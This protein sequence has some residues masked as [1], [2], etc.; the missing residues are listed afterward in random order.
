MIDV[1]K[2]IEEIY[3]PLPKTDVEYTEGVFPSIDIITNGIVEC[4]DPCACYT[5]YIPEGTKVQR[6][7][8]IRYGSCGLIED[9]TIFLIGEKYIIFNYFFQEPSPPSGYFH[10][11]E[12][13]TDLIILPDKT[14]LT[15]YREYEHFYQPRE[16][17]S[18]GTL[19]IG[20]VE[21]EEEEHFYCPLAICK[22]KE[23][24]ILRLTR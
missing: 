4:S 2:L 21:E 22:G 8:L 7:N 5:L 15:V 13:F 16:W 19:W 10:G 11:V 6:W 20:D 18:D 9:A 14:Q 17:L 1:I 3:F 23:L 12:S 24:N